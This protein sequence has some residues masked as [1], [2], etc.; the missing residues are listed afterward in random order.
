MKFARWSCEGGNK[1]MCVTEVLLSFGGNIGD[2]VSIFKRAFRI[3]VATPFIEKVFF[4]R[5][6][7]TKPVSDI[8]QN[9]YVNAAC[10]FE[11]SLSLRELFGVLQKIERKLGKQPKAKNAPRILDIDILLF[12]LE[13]CTDPDLLV[14]HPKWRDRLFVLEPL[15]DILSELRVPSLKNPQ[16]FEI[17][18]LSDLLRDFVNIEGEDVQVLESASI[19][20]KENMYM[21]SLLD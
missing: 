19:F 7:R 1:G 12:G 17:L 5:L 21:C 6:Y 10:R 18:R 11:T 8:P 20:D 13:I 14:P 9:F 4:S 2:T 3:I 16:G 15:S